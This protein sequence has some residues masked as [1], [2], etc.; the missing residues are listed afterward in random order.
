MKNNSQIVNKKNAGFTLLELVVVIGIMGLMSTMAMDLYTDKSNQKRFELTK[1]R[2]AEIKFAVIGD[3]MMRVGSQ[4]VLSGYYSDMSKLPGNLD[5]LIKDPKTKGK[6]DTSGVITITKE[7]DCISPA[8]WSSY[9]KGPYL[10][11]LQS[12]VDD[13]GN[14]DKSDDETVYV[15]AD[16]W[17]NYEDNVHFGWGFSLDSLTQNLTITSLGLDREI[18]GINFES[19]QSIVIYQTEQNYLDDMEESKG[20]CID[21]TDSANYQ[22]D[23][24]K[25]QS[26]CTS[27][28]LK[29]AAFK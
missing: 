26:E 15:F 1:Q 19:D 8:I 14:D 3:P 17:G 23:Q 22:I 24:E 9:W 13:K 21:I 4:A 2:L 20:Y 7:T 29:W 5:Q 27:A 18:G 25:D 6:C 12:F 10:H 16:A 11:N 28:S